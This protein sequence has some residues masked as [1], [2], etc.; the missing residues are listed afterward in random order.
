M[1]TF[2]RLISAEEADDRLALKLAATDGRIYGFEL[3]REVAE[4]LGFK[5]IAAGFG[6]QAIAL[7]V[8]SQQWKEKF[9]LA[10]FKAG[11]SKFRKE[12]K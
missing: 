11:P 12:A 10:Q 3:T 8:K 5:I 2:D 6:L 7:V 9:P 1:T 4:T